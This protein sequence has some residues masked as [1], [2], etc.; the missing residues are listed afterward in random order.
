MS[1]KSPNKCGTKHTVCGILKAAAKG[2]PVM[3]VA[4]GLSVGA[5]AAQLPDPRLDEPLAAREAGQSAPRKALVV[6]G[7]CFWG[8]Q[9]VFQ[10]VKGVVSAESGYAGGKASTANY[11]SVCGGQTGHA[12]A[13]KITYKASAIT[14]GRL[15]KIFF[16]VAHDPTQMGGQGPDHG[17]QYRSAV[18]YANEGQRRIAEAYIAQLDAAKVFKAPIAT[19]LEALKEFYLAEAYHQDYARLHPD[20]PYIVYHDLPKLNDLK[21][22]FPGDYGEP[23]PQKESAEK[24][25]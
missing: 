21:Q 3:G 24:Q 4:V 22:S 6:A 5:A 18:F 1:L 15:L 9:A 23:A 19:R 12:E 2:I 17:D 10:H 11:E 20:A 14:M 7:G 25:E 8:V 13:V 16:S